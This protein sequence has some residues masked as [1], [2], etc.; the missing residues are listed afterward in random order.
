MVYLLKSLFFLKAKRGYFMKNVMNTYIADELAKK[1]KILSQT[2]KQ[3]KNIVETLEKEN[4]RLK[5]ILVN[6]MSIENTDLLSI[7]QGNNDR[8]Y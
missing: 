5:D 8:L 3:T 1:V 7:T 6:L 2:L 4:H